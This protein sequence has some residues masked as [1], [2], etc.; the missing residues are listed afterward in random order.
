MRPAADLI[1][2]PVNYFA[3][4]VPRTG[5]IEPRSGYDRSTLDGQEI[6]LRVQKK[7][8][9]SDPL[10]QAEVPVSRLFERGGYRFQVNGR[11]DGIFRLETPL[12]EE[13]KSC[14]NLW[15]LKR[16]LTGGT[17][18][19]PYSLQLLTYGYF[20]WLE[21][22]VVPNLTFH[23]VSSRNGQ[24]EDIPILLDTEKYERWLELRLDELALE[25]AL[26]ARRSQ[27][28]RK[29]AA[30]FPFPFAGPRP[31]QVEL[32]QE[33]GQGMAAGRRMLIQA[34]TG[35][36]KTVGVLHLC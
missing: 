8:S 13:I 27:R 7:R 33:I 6:H 22:G 9:Q 28:R 20:H 32:M 14:F 15:E 16:K 12:I 3:L 18:E 11:M 24:S 35:L 25:A 36:G 26:A 19:E 31:G 4:P 10:Y 29:I 1:N 21:H 2:I 23:L 5:S 34:P 17:L 30:G